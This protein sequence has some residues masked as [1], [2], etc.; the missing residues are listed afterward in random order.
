MRPVVG[1]ALPSFSRQTSLENW[2]RFAAVN[3]EF[4]AVHMDDDAGRRAGNPSGAFGM[5]NLR[6]SY[7]MNM[8]RNW[9]EGRGEVRAIELR[10]RELNQKGD[11]LTAVGFVTAVAEHEDE[12]RVELSVDVV[13]QHGTSTAPGKATVSFPSRPLNNGCSNPG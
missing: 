1:D 2:N 8:L 10:Y 13:N 7:V 12:I 11:V 9:C 5:G 6:L 3:D 4:I